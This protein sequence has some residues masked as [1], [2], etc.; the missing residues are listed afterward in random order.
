MKPGNGLRAAVYHRFHCLLPLVAHP[1]ARRALRFVAWVCVAAYFALVAAILAL[2]YV[3]LPQI[4]TYRPTIERV[5]GEGLGLQVSIG[6]VEASWAGINPDLTLHDVRV[7]DRDGRPAL[8]FS[9]VEA[10][11]SWWSAPAAN[12]RL[13]VLRIDE[14]TLHLRRDAAGAYFVAGIPLGDSGEEGGMSSWVLEQRRIRIRGATIVW[15][16]DL[17]AAPALVLEDVNLALDNDGSRHRFGLTALPPGEMASRIDVRGDFRGGDFAELAEWTGQAYAAIDYADLAVWSRW[18]DYPVALPQGRGA[19]RAWMT[20]A[21]GVVREMT[22]DLALEDVSLQLRRDLPVLALNRMAGRLS[23]RL[24]SGSAGFAA[25][26]KRVTLETRTSSPV[27]A[28][29]SLRIEPTDFQVGWQREGDGKTVL[30]NIGVSRADLSVLAGL[31]A[32][33]PLDAASRQMLVALLG[34]FAVISL[35]TPLAHPAIAA[36]WF[37]LPNLYFLLPVPL[38][39]ILVSGWLWRTLHQRDRHVSPFTLTLGLVFLGFSGLG[40]SIW[41]HIIPPAITL[42]QAAAP[43]QSQGFMLVGALLIIPVIL[44]YTCWSYYVFRGKV[45]PGEGYH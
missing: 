17:R 35:W 5:V 37:S 20:L 8:A 15:E 26:G 39:V 10:I 24:P 31:A 25:S 2:R 28:A 23:L 40:I 11:I 7:A 43:P 44:G 27:G 41:P 22:T 6:R 9:R 18:V 19:V 14:P 1:F 45:Q 42:W 3:V 21:D 38:L 33:L 4:E 29:A 13:R 16:D 34:V 30:G 12:L 32:Y 36:R